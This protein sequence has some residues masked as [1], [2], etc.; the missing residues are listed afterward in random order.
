MSA[1]TRAELL[2]DISSTLES[3]AR[4]TAAE[5][6]TVLNDVVDSATIPL[7]DGAP[8]AV[9]GGVTGTLSDQADLNSALVSLDTRL[10]RKEFDVKD[11]GAIGDGVAND[12]SAVQAG[13][14]QAQ[15]SNGKLL[16]PAGTFLVDELVVSGGRFSIRGSGVGRTIIKSRSGQSIIK[17]GG[18]IDNLSLSGI[19]FE[20]HATIGTGH[21]VY[22]DPAID[23][24]FNSTIEDCEF[25]S[26]KGHGLYLKSEGAFSFRVQNCM[27]TLCGLDGFRCFGGPGV[28]FDSCTV[29]TVSTGR[30]GFRVLTY[31]QFINCNGIWDGLGVW[32]RFGGVS[33]SSESDLTEAYPTVGFLNCNFENC[34]DTTLD[35][36]NGVNGTSFSQCYFLPRAG[37]TNQ[38][39]IRVYGGRTNAAGLTFSGTE[40][41]KDPTS[42][43]DHGVPVYSD[44]GIW[45][46]SNDGQ[47]PS[48]YNGNA[49]LVYAPFAMTLDGVDNAKTYG[50]TPHTVGPVC[51]K[52]LLGAKV[53]NDVGDQSSN[54]TYRGGMPTSGTFTA[55]DKVWAT[56]AQP[57][58]GFNV[59]KYVL[60]GWHRLTTG[61]NHVLGTDWVEM[62][63]GSSALKDDGRLDVK[64]FGAV[65]DGVANDTGPIA[66]AF[67]LSAST[68]KS[69]WFPYGSYLTDKIVTNSD[70]VLVYGERSRI[71]S[72]L[73]DTVMEI[74]GTDVT[75]LHISGLSFVG[76]S[77]GSGDGL[78]TSATLNSLY[79]GRIENCEFVY[80]GRHGLNFKCPGAFGFVVSDCVA[81]QN[82]GDQFRLSGGPGVELDGCLCGTV[83]TG[84]AG[85]RILGDATLNNCNG[86]TGGNGV[87]GRFG[88]DGTSESDSRTVYPLISM[89]NCNVE[90]YYQIGLEWVQQ[91]RITK[92]SQC[93]FL[94]RNAST[95]VKPIRFLLGAYDD[96]SPICVDTLR[97]DL[98][99]GASYSVSGQTIY[100]ESAGMRLFSTSPNITSYRDNGAGL[101]YPA[102]GPTL[103]W[104]GNISAYGFPHVGYNVP[105]LANLI[106]MKTG[107]AIN[108]GNNSTFFFQRARPTTGTWAAGDIVVR[109]GD[110]QEDPSGFG[111][112][113]LFG[114][115]R[116][117]A[118][119]GN[120]LGTDWVEMRFYSQFNN[121]VPT[122]AGDTGTAGAL[123]WDANYMYVCVATNTWKRVAIATW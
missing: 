110:T 118:G 96:T 121:T 30:A 28:L 13:I 75:R 46:S 26:L 77:S 21:G 112:T 62:R 74:G 76:T 64:A 7:T 90:D 81:D 32:G 42:S 80:N 68:K 58:Q 59:S 49:G 67:S 97:F 19:T 47:G 105:Y 38:R 29:K 108:D 120:T 87:W 106:A 66:A 93:T 56:G 79:N 65:G 37:I 4:N 111:K 63:M 36:I 94:C 55:G 41:R 48:I 104:N 52:N 14:A 83:P 10:D 85:Y 89:N 39:A 54:W 25:V 95:G 116:L 123:A 92:I 51:L 114:W 107:N 27:A 86:L 84:K 18:T 71:T 1:K 117:T 40:F 5:V 16:I 82:L 115:R 45:A 20:G 91:A 11:F 53:G 88:G 8:S 101:N 31:A 113:T 35:F 33:A 100:N 50:M 109:T 2:S 12:T 102:I 6:R 43:W 17:L 73:G 60:I 3:G 69:V 103:D 70:T 119:S 98:G 23:W 61:S 78:A 15:S 9:W 122:F 34:A 22:T 57:E 72:R 24:F 99:S 44:F